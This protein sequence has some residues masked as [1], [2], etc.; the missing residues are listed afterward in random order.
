MHPAGVKVSGS[1]LAT[2]NV[3]RHDFHG[4]WKYTISPKSKALQQ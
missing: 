4:E 2:V 1:D 3:V